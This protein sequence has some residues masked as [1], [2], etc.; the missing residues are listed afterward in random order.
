MWTE[1]RLDQLGFVSRGR[2]RHRPRNEAAL[3]GGPYPFIQTAEVKAASFRI[4]SHSQTYTEA[5]LAQSRIW[6]TNTLCITIA[7]NIADTAL[8]S[9][10]ACFPDSIIG[11]VADEKK[12]DVRFVKY[13]FDIVQERMQM[14]SHGATQDN[15]SQEKLLRFGIPCPPLEIQQAIGNL[16][17]S[18]DDLLETNQ[19]RIALLEESAR[20]LYREWFVS[21]RFP[22]HATAT[23]A[24]GLPAGW[25]Q[26]PI[27][28]MVAFLNRGI[29][30]KYDDAAPGTVINQ[31]CI[32][33]GRLNLAPARRQAKDVKPER[34]LQVGDVL[35]NSTG[36]GTLG[37][38]AQVRTTLENCTADTHVTIVRP[39]DIE[40][41]GFLGVALLELE[42]LFSRM[43]VGSTNQL[44]LGRADIGS[45]LMLT[46]TLV[47]QKRFH[48]QVWPLF[49]QVETL[50][51]SNTLL[52][53]ARDELLPK[54]MSGALQV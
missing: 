46:P 30:P 2:S 51:Q 10:P 28:E 22:G 26:Q 20:L 50:A 52:A 41:A 42:P 15:L 53:T 37:R 32:R 31:K 54:L 36:A 49:N 33:G 39:I 24:D 7:A 21:L 48:D 23:K 45:H 14:V 18:Y 19:R 3:Y 35:I 13:Y 11:F 17:S 47:V 38:V 5:G 4:T 12:C 27:K 29:A 16:L 43:G 34:M 1:V 8:L 25:C 9:Y 44:E 40:C 6:P